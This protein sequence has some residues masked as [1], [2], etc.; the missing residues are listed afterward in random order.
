M[1]IHNGQEFL[2]E[3]L[4]SILIQLNPADE[5]VI[6]DDHS[7][8]Q[9]RFIIQQFNDPR[10]KLLDPVHFNDPI[11]NF[12]FVLQHCSHDYLFLADQDDVW[13]PQK[14][15]TL[16]KELSQCDLIV[17]DCRITDRHLNQ[18]HPSIFQHHRAKQGL[19]QNWV[20]SSFV[21]CCMAF[22]RKVLNKAIPFPSGIPMH[23]QWI[24]LV[25][26]KYF[27]VKFLPQVLLDHRVH[28]RN[29]SSTGKGSKN[30]LRKMISARINLARKLLLVP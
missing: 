25:A 2:E 5:L 13:Y 26:E 1:A 21:G 28:D 9:S 11:K 17:C 3:Q 4:R 23:D 29:Y 12:E 19:V 7:T 22:H 20:K 18:I 10:I 6:S 30:T 15:N 27:T 8:D 16:L 14:I 24:G